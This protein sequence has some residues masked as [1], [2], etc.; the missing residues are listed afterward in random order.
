MATTGHV[1]RAAKRRDRERGDA[2]HRM[3]GRATDIVAA[4]ANLPR[5]AASAIEAAAARLVLV[6]AVSVRA[7]LFAASRSWLIALV[8]AYKVF[9]VARCHG[10]AA[11]GVHSAGYV[12]GGVADGVDLVAT[13]RAVAAFRGAS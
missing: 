4:A 11:P 2:A 5:V 6:A 10:N 8:Y 1:G 12:S 9:G 3:V 7:R 13:V